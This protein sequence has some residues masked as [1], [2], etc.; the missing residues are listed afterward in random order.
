M[1]CSFPAAESQRGF[2]RFGQTRIV[3]G[4]DAK[5]ILYDLNDIFSASVDSRVALFL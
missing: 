2:K 3:N 5:T 1:N 4:S